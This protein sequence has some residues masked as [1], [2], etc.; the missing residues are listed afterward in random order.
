MIYPVVGAWQWGGGWLAELGF[1]DFAGSTIVHLTGGVAALVGAAILG[2]RIGKYGKDGKPRAIPGHNIAARRARHPAAV[3]RLV[4]LQRRLGARARWPACSATSSSP[5]RSPVPAAGSRRRFFT[6][7]RNGKF[8]VAMTA[9]GILAGLV[10]IT[11]GA[12]VASHLMAVAGR[13]DRRCRWSP[14]RSSV[15]RP[16]RIDDPVGASAV[17]GVCGILGT[18]WVGLA[19]TDDGLFYGGGA[20]QLGYPGRRRGRDA[21]RGSA[22]RLGRPVQP[23]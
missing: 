16:S 15:D 3:L 5:P 20:A 17:H 21:S 4:R 10:G 23:L 1:Y 14:S 19:H 2:P 13:P 12:D 9:N 7:L 6:R 8:D 22:P 11:A 18:L